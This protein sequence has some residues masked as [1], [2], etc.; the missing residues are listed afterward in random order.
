MFRSKSRN[1]DVLFA[2]DEFGGDGQHLLRRLA[3]AKDY[4]W[5]ILPQRAV[6]IYLRES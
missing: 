6:Q 5:E 1:Q 3:S 4:L 2:F